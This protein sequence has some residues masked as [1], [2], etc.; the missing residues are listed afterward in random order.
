MYE[1]ERHVERSKEAQGAAKMEEQERAAAEVA[2]HE[3]P[4][5]LV[6]CV[7]GFLGAPSLARRVSASPSTASMVAI[8]ASRCCSL[9]VTEADQLFSWGLVERTVRRYE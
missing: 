6:V 7:L 2:L 4:P 5:E 8:A 3:L 9:A 1:V